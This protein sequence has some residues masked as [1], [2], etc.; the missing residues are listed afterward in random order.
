MTKKAEYKTALV[1]GASSGIGAACVRTLCARG[2]AVTALARRADRLAELA[3]ETG[4]TPLS[5]DLQDTKALYAALDGPAFD[6]L[7]NNAG[8]G[9]SYDGFFNAPTHEIDEMIAL[10]VTASIHVVRAVAKGMVDRGKGHI[11]NMGS[12]S[13]RYAIGVPVYGAT[14]GAVHLFNQ[15]LRLELMGTGVRITEILPG[16]VET[17]MFEQAIQREQ[18]RRKF[19]EE[20]KLLQPEDIASAVAYAIQAPWHVNINS[21]ELM[22]TEQ[23]PFGMSIAPAGDKG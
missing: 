16:R 13:G 20:M 2:L 8:I 22:P 11:V 17:E 4:C 18:D 3:A 23:I 19:I 10:N 6:V 15:N 14:K 5:L 7:I 12:I 1:T 9:R 21:I